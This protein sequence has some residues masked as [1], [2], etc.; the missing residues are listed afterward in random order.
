MYHTLLEFQHEM[1]FRGMKNSLQNLI[2][3]PVFVYLESDELIEYES[4]ETDALQEEK[5]IR[6][7]SQEFFL[8]SS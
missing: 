1:Q 7:W 5:T 2:W 6:I 3:F 8:L 4:V